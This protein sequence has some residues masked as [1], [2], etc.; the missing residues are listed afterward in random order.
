ME[1]FFVV[2][3]LV[4]VVWLIVRQSRPSE[5]IPRIDELRESVPKRNVPHCIRKT[6]RFFEA[7]ALGIFT[8]RLC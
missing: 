4:A 1:D 3:L 6:Y 5:A 8:I 7:V 2:V